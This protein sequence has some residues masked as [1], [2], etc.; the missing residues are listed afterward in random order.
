MIHSIAGIDFHRIC[1]IT[2]EI[3][4]EGRPIE[5]LPQLEYRNARGLRLHEYGQGPFCRFT[6]PSGFEGKAGVYVLLLDEKPVYVG[7]CGDLSTRYNNGYGNISPRN[8]YTGGQSTNCRINSLILEA[9][10][11][12]SAIELLFA[13]SQGRYGLE[14]F[15]ITELNP[16]WNKTLGKP[17]KSTSSRKLLRMTSPSESPERKG[18][19]SPGKYYRLEEYLKKCNDDV[20]LSF[21]EMENIIGFSLPSSA[22]IYNAWW[23]N[24][25]HKHASAWN[26]ANMETASINLGKSVTFKRK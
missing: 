2:L 5:Y 6:I 18:K 12:G 11:N 23:E 17:S 13:E 16:R 3:N 9:M 8:C 21:K 22:R 26:N 1:K 25:G 19:T 14:N 10:K 20:T 4:S 15:L 7:E 24:Y